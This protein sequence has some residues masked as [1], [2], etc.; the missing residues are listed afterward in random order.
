MA[1]LEQKISLQPIEGRKEKEKSEYEWLTR[2]A[3]RNKTTFWVLILHNLK[4][5]HAFSTC[6][7]LQLERSALSHGAKEIINSG[8]AGNGA[9]LIITQL[10]HLPRSFSI[11]SSESFIRA[12]WHL[13]DVAVWRMTASPRRQ[14]GGG[15]REEKGEKGRKKGWG[16]KG[17]RGKKACV[18]DDLS[19]A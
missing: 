9:F 19:E 3:R 14:D 15:G 4:N 11:L 8:E 13:T 18:T 16:M 10:S 1:A 2:L 6:S 12:S 7:T 17:G 5:R